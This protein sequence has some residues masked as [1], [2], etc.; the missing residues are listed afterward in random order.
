ME[1]GS[2]GVRK[3]WVT[4]P[5]SPRPLSDMTMDNDRPKSWISRA[6]TWRSV[7]RICFAV[8]LLLLFLG[9]AAHIR[10]YF[11]AKRIGAVLAGLERVRVDQTT[12]AEL[13]RDV[14]YLSRCGQDRPAGSSTER[15]Y[16]VLISN[17]KDWLLGGPLLSRPGDWLYDL[18]DFLGYRTLIFGAEVRLLDGK[19]SHIGYEV[20]RR[21]DIFPRH[22]GA[23]VSV[24]SAHGFWSP[25]GY[26]YVSSTDDESPQFR[27]S[28]DEKLLSATYTSD[29]PAELAS[30]AFR[31]DLACFWSPRGGCHSSSQVAPLWWQRKSAIE[32]AAL[33]RLTGPNPCPDRILAA[34]VRY[35]PDTN[36]ELLDVLRSRKMVV[37]DEAAIT[38]EETLTDFRLRSVLRG[39][40]TK[41][42]NNVRYSPF[43]SSPTERGVGILNPVPAFRNPGAQALF[44]SGSFFESCRII[45]ATPSAISAVRATVPVSKYR[46]DL[47]PKMFI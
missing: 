14:P 26:V 16:G 34:R 39:R 29:A 8:F 24:D 31:I 36:V 44:F 46:E 2:G 10:C 5:S 30:L 25:S 17:E 47:T 37:N 6:F 32:A 20:D 35:Y 3:T 41:A 19:V 22:S 18:D 1:G 42:L 9:T 12:E 11:L 15:R 4:Y 21:A 28:G 38:G 7:R 13:L 43:I 45:P 23:I 27:V 33:V 40:P